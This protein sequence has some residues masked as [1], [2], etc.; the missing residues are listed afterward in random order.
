VN[1]GSHVQTGR[2]ISQRTRSLP[3]TGNC[4]G[5]RRDCDQHRRDW[6]QHANGARSRRRSS[7]GIEFG[8]V[9]HP[10]LPRLKCDRQNSATAVGGEHLRPARVPLRHPSSSG[11]WP[12]RWFSPLGQRPI[13]PQP[14]H[15]LEAHLMEPMATATS[16]MLR[17]SR[18][19]RRVAQVPHLRVDQDQV[20]LIAKGISIF[21][22]AL[23]IGFTD[24]LLLRA[25]A[26]GWS[27]WT[28]SALATPP[29]IPP[30]WE[31]P[32]SPDRRAVGRLLMKGDTAHRC[33]PF[34][35]SRLWLE[36]RERAES[37]SGGP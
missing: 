35:F 27:R 28:G 26:K 8:S 33:C 24:Q 5:S 1:G 20:P 15:A 23:P 16:H 2:R 11:R 29:L 17:C 4:A 9:G 32:N 25:R 34:S 6:L 31:W 13:S 36:H 19:S 37:A 12:G 14:I 7:D 30:E 21:H 22:R 10:A 18:S 3:R